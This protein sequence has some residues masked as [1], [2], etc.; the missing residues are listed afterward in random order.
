MTRRGHSFI[1]SLAFINRFCII[2]PMAEKKWILIV[3]DEVDLLEVL[4][5]VLQMHNY[6]VIGV[7]SAKLALKNIENQKFFC[8]LLDLNLDGDEDTGQKLLKSLKNSLST[9]INRNTPVIVCSGNIDSKVIRDMRSD[10]S[11]A[12]TKPVD[13]DLLIERLKAL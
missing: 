10:I 12:M 7:T 6:E 2:C 13:I 1:F 9:V 4:G 8:I 11:Y 5:E 3:E